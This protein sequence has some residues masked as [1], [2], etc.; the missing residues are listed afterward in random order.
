MAREELDPGTRGC[1]ENSHLFCFPSSRLHSQAG[2]SL[3]PHHSGDMHLLMV[4]EVCRLRPVSA[5]G[6][7]EPSVHPGSVTSGRG[8]ARGLGSPGHVPAV[9]N[10]GSDSSSRAVS[11]WGGAVPLRASVTRGR[12]EGRATADHDCVLIASGRGVKGG[13]T[14]CREGQTESAGTRRW[15]G[16]CAAA[17]GQDKLDGGF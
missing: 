9:S 16:I 1:H 6:P 12:L 10:S 14:H 5:D 11:A 3:P 15:G 2:V 7:F 4:A 13:R 17:R 8:V